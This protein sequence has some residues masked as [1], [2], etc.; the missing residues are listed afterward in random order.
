MWWMLAPALAQ[1]P[2]DVD[3]DDLDRWE[4]TAEKILD[5]PTG[6]WEWVGQASWD[7]DTGRFGSTRGDA[8]FAGRT[9]GGVWGVVALQ[10]LGEMRAER[11]RGAARVYGRDALFMPLVGRVR[12]ERVQVLGAERDESLSEGVEAVNTLRKALARVS[13]DAFTSTADW[14]QERGGVVLTRTIPLAVGR[15]G[16][17]EVEVFFPDGGPA[18][19]TLDV[20]F[21]MTFKTGRFPR[22][23]IRDGEAQ[24]RGVVRGD[25]VFPIS[26]AFQFEY[27]FL[28]FRFSGAQTIGYKHVSRCPAQAPVTEG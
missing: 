14:D 10:P 4:S 1:T 8:V 5:L 2:P 20:R 15:K 24:I 28:G 23:T 13:G 6:C 18:P 9:D 17:I 22:W 16:E 7:W 3:L 25:A 27:G 11:G 19:S 12:G 21:P 26:E